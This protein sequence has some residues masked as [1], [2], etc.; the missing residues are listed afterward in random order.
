MAQPQ[1]YNDYWMS[2]VENRAQAILEAFAKQP[3]SKSG[4]CLQ[5]PELI[6]DKMGAHLLDH[7]A[8]FV[9]TL[10]QEEENQLCQVGLTHGYVLSAPFR[11]RYT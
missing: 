5:S 6:T 3:P 9:Y 4:T 2:L 11:Q 10:V 1:P 8:W 7:A